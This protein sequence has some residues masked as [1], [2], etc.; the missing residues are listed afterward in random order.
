MD[1]VTQQNAAMMEQATAASH[2]LEGEATELA[3]LV[4]QFQTAGVEPQARRRA[5][6]NRAPAKSRIPADAPMG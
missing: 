1:Q 5:A 2:S 3:P 4:G 6:P